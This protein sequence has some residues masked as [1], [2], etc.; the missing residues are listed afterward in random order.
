MGNEGIACAPSRVITADDRVILLS[1]SAYPTV[2]SQQHATALEPA[3]RPESFRFDTLIC[4]WRTSWKDG[5]RLRTRI[6]TMTEAL[7][8]GTLVFLNMLPK[9]DF[10]A[11]M[12]NGEF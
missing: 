12:E 8:A 2:A 10:K 5:K 7:K 1:R 4:G 3:A 6:L 9:A 11:I